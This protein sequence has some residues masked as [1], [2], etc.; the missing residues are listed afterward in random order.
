MTLISSF[1]S[2]NFLM[3][4]F[5]FFCH[6]ND[7]LCNRFSETISCNLSAEGALLILYYVIFT[8][9]GGLFASGIRQEG[10]GDLSISVAQE[11]CTQEMLDQTRRETLS[12]IC[13]V[14]H[15][16]KHTLFLSIFSFPPVIHH[17]QVCWGH[18][19]DSTHFP[20]L[21]DHH[22]CP[23]PPCLIRECKTHD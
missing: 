4:F 12:Y 22:T 20:G 15:H 1:V 16:T 6:V 19:P 23:P 21:W 13:D 2:H 11:K 3:F 8:F 5:L 7:S 18:T 14:D 9:S 17:R 10:E